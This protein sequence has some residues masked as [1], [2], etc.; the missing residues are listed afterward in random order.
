[1]AVR[2]IASLIALAWVTVV[3]SSARA[4]DKAG[5]RNAISVHPFSLTSHGLA[6]QYERYLKPRSFSLVLGLGVRSSSRSD[7]SSWATSV[8]IEPRYWLA[9]D[10]T[11]SK[12]LGADAM[13]GPYLSLRTDVAYL[14]MT[15]T[16][17]DQWVGGNIGLSFVGSFGWRFAIGRVEI[18]PSIGL[19]SRTDFDAA[20]RLAPWTR[21]VYRFDW[22]VGWMF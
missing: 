2:F 17:R 16:T 19:G 6:V 22:T 9:R 10:P 3:A 14:M 13:I 7:Y 15:D 4:Q 8:G 18:T 12:R 5:P 20:G 1:V 11:R 21:A